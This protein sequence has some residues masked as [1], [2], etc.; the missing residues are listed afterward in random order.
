MSDHERLQREL[1]RVY[2]K[3]FRHGFFACLTGVWLF[4]VYM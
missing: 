1:K 2:G 4:Y 3:A